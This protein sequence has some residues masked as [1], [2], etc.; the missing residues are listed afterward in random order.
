[1]SELV[2]EVAGMPEPAVLR[3][4]DS[5]GQTVILLGARVLFSYEGTDVRMRNVAV[6]AVTDAGVPCRRAAEVFELT[7]QYVSMPARPGA[8][9]GLGRAGAPPRPPAQAQ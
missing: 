4:V 3:R 7:L 1:M 6:V 5:D 9:G 2:L 8:C